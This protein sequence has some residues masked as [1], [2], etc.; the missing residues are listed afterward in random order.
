MLADEPVSAADNRQSRVI[1]DALTETFDTV[2]MA[3]HDVDLALSY[4][5]RIIGIRNAGIALDA[6]ADQLTRADL[7]FL[8]ADE[9]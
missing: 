5:T 6:P 2:I 8:Y 3:M 9:T 7:D 4:S 1:L